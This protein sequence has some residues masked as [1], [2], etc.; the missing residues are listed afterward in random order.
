MF[1]KGEINLNL[2]FIILCIFMLSIK[3][4]QFNTKCPECLS[5]VVHSRKIQIVLNVD[6]DS[7]S[8]LLCDNTTMYVLIFTCVILIL[9]VLASDLYPRSSIVTMMA[10]H[11]GVDLL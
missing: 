7:T 11:V 4:T 8:N 2:T 1:S 10:D 5:V 9:E 3:A 6:C